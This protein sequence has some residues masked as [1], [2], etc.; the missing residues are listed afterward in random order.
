MSST[1]VCSWTASSVIDYFN[2]NG[3][4]VYAAAMDMSKAFDMVEWVG[5]FS[6]LIKRNVSFC[7]LRLMLYI[8]ENQSCNVKWSGAVSS[9]FSVSNG[10]RQGA[11]SSA[12]LF[13]IYIDEL[14]EILKKSR[15]GC[16]IDGLF[17]GAVVFADDIFL[18]SPTRDCLQSLVTMCQ[19]F[20]SGKNL[21]FGT[22]PNPSKS[23]TKCIV[24][25]KK[26]LDYKLLAPIVLDGMNL[27]RGLK[28]LITWAVFLKQTI[29]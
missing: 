5:L 27:F 3:S 23:K 15:I 26:R 19:K 16:Y 10:V 17:F 29:Q 4:P 21:K 13:G 2:R 9:S 1:V 12:I 18:L 20:A 11:V 6:A 28:E 24:F 14:L 8:Y 25:T 7:I 22:D